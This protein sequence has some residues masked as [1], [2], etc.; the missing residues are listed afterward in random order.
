MALTTP[1]LVLCIVLDGWYADPRT[2]ASI[3][4]QRLKSHVRT[5]VG[6]ITEGV[7]T[8]VTE[9]RH[10]DPPGSRNHPIKNWA[11]S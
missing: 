3:D 11:K 10:D 8:L 7:S 4:S 5:E 9:K 2:T 6:E 1:T